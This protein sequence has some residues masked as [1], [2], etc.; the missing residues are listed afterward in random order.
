MRDPTAKSGPVIDWVLQRQSDPLLHSV[1]VQS[2]LTSK[3][4]SI[5]CIMKVS[6]LK[7]PPIVMFRRKLMAIG[8]DAFHTDLSQILTYH[9]DMTVTELG[10]HLTSLLDKPATVTKHI[11]KRKK[12]TPWFTPDYCCSQREHGSAE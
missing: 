3:H 4:A 1:S 7:C 9:P 11:Q 12:L 5:V 2:V 6:K 10:V 8:T